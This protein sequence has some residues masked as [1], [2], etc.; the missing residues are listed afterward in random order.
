MTPLP[1]PMKLLTIL[2]GGAIIGT[3]LALL[4][5]CVITTP[6][7]WVL[8]G[9][10]AISLVAGVFALVLGLRGRADAL[11]LACVGGTVFAGATL[12]YMGTN[13]PSIGD[14]PL[15]GWTLAHLVLAAGLGVISA[16]L[17]LQTDRASW[18]R[19]LKGV[20]LALP[21]V[22]VLGAMSVGRVRGPVMDLAT[23]LP[24]VVQALGAVVVFLV[25]LTLISVSVHLTI[26]A[27]S[28]R[29]AA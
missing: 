9:F 23:G 20:L 24:P 12:G 19:L 3:S 14:M 15:I 22:G 10:E 17:V 2:L 5:L 28:G 11:A 27:F 7:A 18:G 13:P 6:F 21:V 1:A 26:A 25:G 16:L 8:F 4:V 29:Q